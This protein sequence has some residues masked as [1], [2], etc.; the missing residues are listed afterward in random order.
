MGNQARHITADRCGRDSAIPGD[1]R[2]RTITARAG[3]LAAMHHVAMTPRSHRLR[4]WFVIV[5]VVVGIGG[6]GYAAYHDAQRLPGPELS[7]QSRAEI[8]A[9]DCDHLRALAAR[10]GSDADSVQD[11]HTASKLIMKRLRT[12]CAR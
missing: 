6:V 2:S 7:A 3:N 5:F 8:S 4:F 11:A 10:Y 9:A 1:C 12:E